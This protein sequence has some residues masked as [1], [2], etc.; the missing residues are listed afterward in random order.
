MQSDVEAGPFRLRGFLWRLVKTMACVAGILTLLSLIPAEVLFVLIS[1]MIVMTIV[2]VAILAL[3]VRLYRKGRHQTIIHIVLSLVLLSA[4]QFAAMAW[5]AQR[6]LALEQRQILAPQ[7][8]HRLVVF[9]WTR[10]SC[11]SQCIELLAKTDWQ[12]AGNL[13]ETGEWAVFEAAR[14]EACYA[15]ERRKSHLEFLEAGFS[16]L[17][18]ARTIRPSG[19]SALM[20]RMHYSYGWFGPT[21]GM[22]SYVPRSYSGWV[23][24]VYERSDGEERLLGR[25]LTGH[26][27]PLSYWF[28]LIGL[29]G[30]KIGEHFT[31][32]QFYSM[33]LKAPIVGGRFPGESALMPLFDQLKPYLSDPKLGEKARRALGAL[34]VM[35]NNGD[36]AT[37]EHWAADMLA[38]TDAGHILA[39]LQ[40]LAA[41]PESDLR[42]FEPR[43]LP[44]LHHEDDEVVILAMMIV[45]RSSDEAQSAAI[46]GLVARA[47]YVPVDRLDDYVY[48]LQRLRGSDAHSGMLS[49][50]LKARIAEARSASP[51]DPNLI[52][53]LERVL[54]DL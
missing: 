42:Q 45:R 40:L 2:V 38:S 36:L 16:D 28:G 6:A 25:W 27:R 26:I 34:A 39:G 54:D 33:A 47:R 43:F 51:S 17:C 23:Y 15:P 24:E 46:P 19:D 10:R 37:V 29:D 11:L 7:R 12:P 8:A 44:L 5:D 41:L 1:P 4:L 14:G 53:K 18:A 32:A 9:D 49:E 13:P 20:I 31:P 21:G 22:P 3:M 50:V 30:W 35:N 48:L 52:R